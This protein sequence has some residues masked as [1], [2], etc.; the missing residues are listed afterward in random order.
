[1]I[2]T[3][4]LKQFIPNNKHIDE[5]CDS[6][7]RILPNYDIDTDKRISMFIAQC[8]HESDDFNALSE[9]LH[10][11]AETLMRFW[12]GLFP[13]IDI[14]N[15]YAM[16]PEKIAN[17]AYGN[18]MGNGN[19]ESGDGWKYRGRGIIQITGHENYT[20]L[21]NFL[22]KTVDETVQY[23]STFDGS[24]ES[25]CW[26]WKLHN[27]N[28]FCDIEDVTKVTEIINGGHNGL[29]LEDRKNKYNSAIKIFG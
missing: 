19:E 4:K 5:W 29:G 13:N 11:R 14:A 2:T 8:A 27:I 7:N 12:P 20:K 1:M 21:S 22:N 26:Y 3:D 28:P 9:D 23:L 15:Q 25:A 16:Q 6:L 24:V 10:Y 17:R 18:R